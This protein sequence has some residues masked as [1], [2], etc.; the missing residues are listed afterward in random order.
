MRTYLV[1]F[2]IHQNATHL[3]DEKKLVRGTKL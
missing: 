1:D 2:E 3:S